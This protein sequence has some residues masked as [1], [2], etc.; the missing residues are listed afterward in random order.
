MLSRTAAITLFSGLAVLLGG[1]DSGPRVVDERDEVVRA[2]S[3]EWY[4]ASPRDEDGTIRKTAQAVGAKPRISESFAINQARQAMALAIE[5]RVDVLQR[6]F[7]EQIETPAEPEVLE[8]FQDVNNVVASTT[9]RGSHVVRK[10]TYR[11]PDGQYR[12][13]VMME[14]EGADLDKNYVDAMRELGILE[15][16]LRSGEA[17]AELERRVEEL[18]REQDRRGGLPPMTDEQIRGDLGAGRGGSGNSRE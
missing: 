10:E 8:R 14:L 3:P 7:T 4:E 13:F 18:Q 2:F 17:W 9:L 12:T 16:R 15:N 1:C 5:S 11:E 6:A